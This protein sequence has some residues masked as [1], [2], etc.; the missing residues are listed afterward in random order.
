MVALRVDPFFV[1]GFSQTNDVWLWWV[2]IRSEILIEWLFILQTGLICT[3]NMYPLTSYPIHL[4]VHI[5]LRLCSV[6]GM[7]ESACNQTLFI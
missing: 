7:D 6:E 4:G 2:G 1:H 3:P 5:F